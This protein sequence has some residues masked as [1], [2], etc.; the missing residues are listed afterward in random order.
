VRSQPERAEEL[1]GLAQDDIDARWKL[2][3]QM[4]DVERRVPDLEDHE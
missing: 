3:E 2:Y 4:A 1:F